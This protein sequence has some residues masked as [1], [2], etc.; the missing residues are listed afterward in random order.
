MLVAPLE[1]EISRKKELIKG[2]NIP[3]CPTSMGCRRSSRCRCCSR[4]ATT[5]PPTRSCP[6][7]ARVLPFRSNIPKISMFVFEPVDETYADRAMERARSD[8]G[9]VVIGGRTTGRAR[10]ASTP[11]SPRATSACG[12]DR[13]GLCAHPLAEPHQNQGLQLHRRAYTQRAPGGDHARR[14]PDQL[15]EG[16]LASY[17]PKR[18]G[19]SPSSSRSGSSSERRRFV[20]KRAASAPS[21]MRWS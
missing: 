11:P 8:G 10:A 7:G 14:W 1:P 17:V 18:F 19:Y 20:I 15:G 2:P 5:S 9:H 13:Q 4:S 16:Q 21:Q 12:R 6:A 3:R